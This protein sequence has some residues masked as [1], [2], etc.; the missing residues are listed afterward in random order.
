MNMRQALLLMMP[1]VNKD[2][3]TELEAPSSQWEMCTE[4]KIFMGGARNI[5]GTEK[6]GR[7]QKLHPQFVCA[8][9]IAAPP[10]ALK[11]YLGNTKRVYHLVERKY[12]FNWMFKDLSMSKLNSHKVVI[13]SSG[14]RRSTKLGNSNHLKDS[15]P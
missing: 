7:A 3:R 11:M 13:C 6:S 10:I 12:I 14:G 15:T 4:E 9:N 8:S 2:K 5:N 1:E